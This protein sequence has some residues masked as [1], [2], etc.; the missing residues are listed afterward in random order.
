MRTYLRI[1]VATAVFSSA[2]AANALVLL[3]TGNTSLS[4]G[5]SVQNNRLFR[6]GTPTDWYNSPV[7]PGESAVG[8]VH[9]KTYDVAVGLNNYVQ[10]STDDPNSLIFVSVYQTAYNPSSKSTNYLGD[11]GIS[12]NDFGNPHSFQ[13]LAALNSHIQ[14][15]V[16]EISLNQG[17]GSPYQVLVEGFSDSEY[18]EAVPEPFT[19]AGLSLVG[20]AALRRRRSA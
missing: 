3:D 10:V 8:N 13:V 17:V 4:S 15:V 5:D 12:G 18:N 2:L 20:L 6:S 1:F 7:Y 16:N 19:L 14:V 9:Y 11:A